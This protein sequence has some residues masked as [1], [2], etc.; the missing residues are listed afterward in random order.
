MSNEISCRHGKKASFNFLVGKSAAR[1]KYD[2]VEG[3][4]NICTM[5]LF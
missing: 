5:G 4:L 3:G 2:A 1:E